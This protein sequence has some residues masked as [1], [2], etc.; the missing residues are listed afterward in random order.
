MS[1]PALC[2]ACD[3]TPGL[4][5]G[6]GTVAVGS[7]LLGVGRRMV[8]EECMVSG[9]CGEGHVRRGGD[10]HEWKGG[11]VSLRFLVLLLRVRACPAPTLPHFRM[12][13]SGSHEQ[14]VGTLRLRCWEQLQPAASSCGSLRQCTCRC[15]RAW[16]FPWSCMAVLGF[17]LQHSSES[18]SGCPHP[19][20]C[21]NLLQGVSVCLGAWLL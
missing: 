16:W 9:V 21:P 3:R 15:G 17:P 10:W 5:A 20:P 1:L 11:A 2:L 18:E 4:R 13:L 7:C 14:P 12:F 8:W 19:S 6:P